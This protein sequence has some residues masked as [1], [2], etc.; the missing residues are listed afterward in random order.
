MK[1]QLILIANA[2]E[3]RLL[4]RSSSA[5]PMELLASLAHAPSRAKGSELGDERAGHASM[6]RRPGGVSFPPRATAKQKEHVRFADELAQRLDRE[7]AAGQ[8]DR[9]AVFASS[10]FLGELKRRLSDGARK[11][12]RVTV[13][14]DLTS[15]PLGELEGRIGAQLRAAA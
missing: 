4:R 11:A 12:L 6:D 1:S 10:P 3:A 9:V 13:D 14:T 2:G 15:V 8:V 7:L 5:E